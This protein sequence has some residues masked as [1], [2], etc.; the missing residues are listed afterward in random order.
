M[1]TKPDKRIPEIVNELNQAQ[2]KADLDDIKSGWGEDLVKIAWSVLTDKEKQRIKDMCNQKVVELK[3]M[4]EAQK[5]K[6]KESKTVAELT[7]AEL[8]I[9]AQEI[10]SQLMEGELGEDELNVVLDQLQGKVDA[11]CWVRDFLQAEKEAAQ[12]RLETI[13]NKLEHQVKLLENNLTALDNRLLHWHQE[14]IL[15][16]KVTGNERTIS[17]RNYPLVDVKVD[18]ENLPD[19]FKVTKITVTPNK[20]ALK[21]AL[22][23]NPEAVGINAELVDNFKVAVGFTRKTK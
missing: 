23:D 2:T 12:A 22:K 11:T 20:T 15:D 21:K 6:V 19:E 3:P 8:S 17:F 7:L 18:P 13:K 4:K 9:E 5:S 10:F 14:G 1:N 16:D